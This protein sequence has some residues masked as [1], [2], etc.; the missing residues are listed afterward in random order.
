MV[1]AEQMQNAMDQQGY[2]LTLES[3]AAGLRL[4]SR[5]FDGDD[6]VAKYFYAGRRLAVEE[7]GEHIGGFPFLAVFTVERAHLPVPH[8]GDAEFGAALLDRAQES[9]GD[10]AQRCGRI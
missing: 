4:A 2:H 9:L 1:V 6:H 8:Q 3:S 5:L 10:A 7:K